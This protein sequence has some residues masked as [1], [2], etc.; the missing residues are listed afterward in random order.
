MAPILAMASGGLSPG[1]LLLL[2]MQL[3]EFLENSLPL[4]GENLRIVG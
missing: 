1:L 2:L 4:L 3:G